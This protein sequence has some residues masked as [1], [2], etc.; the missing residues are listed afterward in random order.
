LKNKDDYDDYLCDYGE[1]ARAQD[2]PSKPMSKPT[3]K[4]QK[5]ANKTHPTSAFDSN[6]NCDESAVHALFRN[7]EFDSKSNENLIVYLDTP[8]EENRKLSCRLKYD[9]DMNL[10]RVENLPIKWLN[11]DMRNQ[12]KGVD[13]SQKK[14]IRFSVISQREIKLDEVNAAEKILFDKIKASGVL[15]ECKTGSTEVVENS[16]EQ[17]KVFAVVKEFRK[18][19]QIFA[20]CSK[21]TKYEGKLDNWREL[22]N[23]ARIKMPTAPLVKRIELIEAIR[24]CLC[25][26][27]ELS[28]HDERDGTFGPVAHRRELII[29]FKLEISELSPSDLK[30]LVCI[31]WH[32]AQVML[33]VISN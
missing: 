2:K 29:S 26:S 21:S 32:V 30:D 12:N 24:V 8:V 13:G 6:I 10:V 3:K 5:K 7:L 9:K 27:H 25:A 16:G 23:V 19:S 20:R 17:T 22:F 15:V 11:V 28:D 33:K 18:N 31:V 4:K 1:E 14:D